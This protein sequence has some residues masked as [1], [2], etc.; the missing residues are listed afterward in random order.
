MTTGRSEGSTELRSGELVHE[1]AE[2]GIEGRE[3][4]VDGPATGAWGTAETGGVLVGGIVGVS[5]AW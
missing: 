2:S 1:N 3:G 5:G 4:A